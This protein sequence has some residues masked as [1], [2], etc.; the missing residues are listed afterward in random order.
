MLPPHG[1]IASAIV[2]WLNALGGVISS[3]VDVGQVWEPVGM[4]G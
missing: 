2:K 4:L 3:F 1:E